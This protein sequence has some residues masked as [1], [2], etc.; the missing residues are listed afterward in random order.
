M[1][2]KVIAFDADDTLWV[3]EP[4][5]R[6]TE[7]QFCILL[8]QYASEHELQRELLK[9][10]IENLGLYGYGIKGFILSM[11]EAAMN[12]T[13][14]T[15]SIEV[16]N[17]I[18]D[19]GKQMLNQPIE[20]LDGVEGVL[21]KLKGKYRLVVATKGD[22]LDQERKLKKSGL[23]PYFHHIEIMSEKDDA[24]YLKLIKHLDIRPDELL[25]VGNS[26]KSDI[27][28]VLNIGGH[29]VHVP[30]HITWAHEQIEDSIDNE[31]F[32]SAVTIKDILAYL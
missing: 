20:L 31:R 25:M 3:N 26:L 23:S 9:I 18:I 24:N 8:Q 12:I 27:M 15:L 10:E 5:F 28:P 14:N 6:Q 11:L 16:V 1:N 29:A 17:Q 21:D 32:K 7:E 13:Q 30:Y 4:Y 2:I 22:L 19:L